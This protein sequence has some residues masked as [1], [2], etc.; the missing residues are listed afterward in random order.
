MDAKAERSRKRGNKY[1]RTALSYGTVVDEKCGPGSG[2]GEHTGGEAVSGGLG[3]VGQAPWRFKSF[4]RQALW[5][6]LA[7]N[8]R[9]KQKGIRDADQCP[10]C[11]NMEDHEH[12]LKKCTYLDIPFQLVRAM[13]K[14]VKMDGKVV[15][16]SRM[17]LEYPTLSLQTTQGVILWTAIHALWIFRCA[18]QFGRQKL[19]AKKYMATWHASLKDWGKWEGMSVDPKHIARVKSS[20]AAWMNTKRR[21]EQQ[22]E[23]GLISGESKDTRKRKRKEEMKE[24]VLGEWG[25]EE[26]PPPGVVQ[27]WT[28]GSEQK[29]L[30]GRAYAGYGAWFG[31]GHILNLA[32][33]L[34]G[35][36][37]TN[38]R[39]EM[40]AVLHVLRIIPRWVELQICTD[41]QLV[42]DAILC[43]MK[44]WER[45]GRKT[46]RGKQV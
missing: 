30:D 41:S 6:K 11:R 2:G 23:P 25:L 37:Q 32:E 20:L 44:G 1:R 31:Y 18:V 17:C 26:E 12:M 36:P 43:W 35:I 45:R 10:L 13:F 19:E 40:T 21:L 5:K 9:L 42:L 16:P 34:P 27:A 28:D 39:A 3:S 14:R 24:N 46:K 22:E 29:G 33:K 4:V 15:E 7:A 38:N 8:S